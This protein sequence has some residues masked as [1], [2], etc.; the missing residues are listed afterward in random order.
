MDTKPT[1]AEVPYV[2][3]SRTVHTV[4]S[5]Q[6]PNREMKILG[7]LNP[8]LRTRPLILDTE[9]R[10]GRE[11]DREKHRLATSRMCPDW[12]LILQPLGVQDK[13]LTN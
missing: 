13:A 4:G 12:G 1:D 7:F 8:H 5:R 10:R 2:K 3:R 11:R 9:K 6:S